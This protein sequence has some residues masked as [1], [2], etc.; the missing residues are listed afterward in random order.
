MTELFQRHFATLFRILNRL[1]GDTELA[2]DLAQEAFVRLYQ[3]GSAPEVPEAWLVTVALNLFRNA[4]TQG[5]RRLQLLERAGIASDHAAAVGGLSDRGA[6]TPE[7]A[8]AERERVQLALARL[9]LRERQLLL[10]RAEGYAYR[11]LAQ[12]LELAPGSVGTLLARAKRAFL[13][14]YEERANASH[15]G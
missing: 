8:H 2:S 13:D 9:P 11:D 10:L 15:D 1:T 14:A 6:P 7:V 3:R 5:S 12:M 4:R